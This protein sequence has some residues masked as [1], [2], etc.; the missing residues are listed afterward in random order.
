MSSSAPS[1]VTRI[2]SGKSARSSSTRFDPL[3]RPPEAPQA[4]A[5]AETARPA[6]VAIV[7]AASASTN[8]FRSAVT[9]YERAL[10]EDALAA[11]GSISAPPRSRL[12]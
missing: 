10:L 1:I 9:D 2:P 3:G 8:D 12:A 11:T 6:A 4:A 7:L 5:D